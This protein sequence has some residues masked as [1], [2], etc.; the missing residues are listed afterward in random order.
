[1]LPFNP[2]GHAAYQD[3]LVDQLSKYYPDPDSIQNSVWEIID[4]FY[5]KDL[6]RLDESLR[7]LYSVFGPAPRLPSCMLRSILVALNFKVASYTEWARQL[8]LNPL[9]A[10]LSGFEFGDTP[11]VGTF[12]DFIKRLWA[13][14]S[15]NLSPHEHKPKSSVK[16]PSKKG[17]KAAPVDKVTVEEL[18]KQLQ[19][20]PP[21]TGQP[22]SWLFDIFKQEF[23]DESASRGLL[24][25]DNLD[26]A[27]DGTP[28]VTS[29]RERKKRLCTCR[30]NGI[31]DCDCPRYYSQPDCD[32]GWD[33]S[34]NRFYHGYDLYMLTAANSEN[35]LP[36]FP[37]LGP[38]SRHDSLGFLYGWFTM[39]AFLPDYQ[40]NKLLLDSAH[41]AMP[42]YEYCKKNHITP[43]IDLNEKRG[44][45]VKYKDDFTIGNDCVPVCK[46]GL[47]MHRD[48]AEKS[49]YRL[50]FRCPLMNRKNGC[51]CADPCS[52]SKFGRTVHLAMKDN[53]RIF[54]IPARGSDEWKLE[55]KA[56]TSAERCN[57]RLKKDYK[58]ED[59]NHR[60]S[61]MWYCRL[62]CVMMCLHLDAWGLP[63]KS[64]LR[65]RLSQ[66]V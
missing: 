44:I 61:K 52:D 33:S 4:Q 30:Q 29:A 41:D 3:F 47:K 65:N 17:T 20:T 37:L 6:S 21:S 45:N 62:F 64:E 10:I 53:P 11:G 14:D 8:K 24:N 13:S 18:L 27:G 25:P 57:K 48:G 1:L 7:G 60:S 38:A 54:N 63:D 66:A 12:Y 34:R 40:V 15:K 19:L 16:K 26:I 28:V 39:R 46:A 59:G 51:A 56:R 23:L 35:D 31:A 58:L 9:Y 42:I 2:G 22:F 36:L 55:Y 49:K 5:L 32:I 43:F 50:K